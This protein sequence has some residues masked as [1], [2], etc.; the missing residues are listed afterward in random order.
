[1]NI[2]P[3]SI[4]VLNKT[5]KEGVIEEYKEIANGVYKI[6]LPGTLIWEN[7]AFQE[8]EIYHQLR[9]WRENVSCSTK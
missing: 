5:K 4:K 1:M 3:E 2:T 7:R 8:I 6:K 9:K